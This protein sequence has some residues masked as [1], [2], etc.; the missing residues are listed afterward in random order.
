MRPGFLYVLE[1]PSDPNLVKIGRTIRSP[2]QR[3]VEHNSDYTKLA[4]KIV[5]ETGQKWKLKEVVAVPDP[6]YAEAAFWETTS[7]HALRGKD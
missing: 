4:G 7:Q 5:K 2:E 6:A 3:L 1:H